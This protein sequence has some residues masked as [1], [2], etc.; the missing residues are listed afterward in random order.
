MEIRIILK[1][2]LIR[3]SKNATIQLGTFHEILFEPESMAIPSHHFFASTNCSTSSVM[4]VEM[5][6]FT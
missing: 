5:P 6:G 3:R 2:R 1:I 4:S